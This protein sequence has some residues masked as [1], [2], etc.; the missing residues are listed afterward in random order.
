LGDFDFADEQPGLYQRR[1]MR[2]MMML[3]NGA[4][5]EGEW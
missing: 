3:E 1:E 4:K 5:Y 2:G